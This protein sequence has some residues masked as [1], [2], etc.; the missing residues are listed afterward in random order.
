MKPTIIQCLMSLP[1]RIELCDPF[2]ITITC[3]QEM[4]GGRR[5]LITVPEQVLAVHRSAL[6]IRAQ[7]VRSDCE[8][9]RPYEGIG[10]QLLARLRN[11][12]IKK[13]Q[14]R[15]RER[16]QHV[17]I[18]MQPAIQ[19]RHRELLE[20]TQELEEQ[21]EMGKRAIEGREEEEE[22]ERHQDDMEMEETKERGMIRMAE[23]T[24]ENVKEKVEEVDYCFAVPA[25]LPSRIAKLKVRR[26]FLHSSIYLS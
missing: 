12:L 11:I 23:S 15:I 24:P 18:P 16:A 9:V 17:G 10:S 21:L 14:K 13:R 5:R 8:I 4:S 22:S 7:A 3:R 26:P 1:F 6:R 19:R 25:L 20:Q 2:V